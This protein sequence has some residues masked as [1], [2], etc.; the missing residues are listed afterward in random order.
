MK[1]KELIA[2]TEIN[3]RPVEIFFDV[4]YV[5]SVMGI[6]HRLKV[7]KQILFTD[8]RGGSVSFSSLD[9]VQKAFIEKEVINE[10]GNGLNWTIEGLE[11]FS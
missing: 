6:R 4:E 7:I 8:H 1:T 5:A 3:N 2:C 11:N 10:T 9:P